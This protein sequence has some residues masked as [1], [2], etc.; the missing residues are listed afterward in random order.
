MRREEFLRICAEENTSA[1]ERTGIGTY[2]EKRLH[3]VLKRYTDDDPTHH[4][5]PLLGYVADIF[6]GDTITEIQTGSLRPLNK[7]IKCYIDNTD[8]NVVVVCPI[9]KEKWMS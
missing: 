3:I 5:F 1:H 7:K 4:E 8:Y 6:D 9:A 2:M